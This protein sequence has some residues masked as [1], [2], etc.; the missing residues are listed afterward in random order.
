MVT[1]LLQLQRRILH[2]TKFS[3][4]QKKLIDTIT[5]SSFFFKKENNENDIAAKVFWAVFLVQVQI[6]PTADFDRAA[7]PPLI[8]SMPQNAR[9]PCVILND[10]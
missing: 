5:T 6:C 1:F 4:F 7:I 2:I 3:D 10:M 8:F 9:T